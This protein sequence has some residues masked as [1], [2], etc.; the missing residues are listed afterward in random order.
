M[1]NSRV[2][3]GINLRKTGITKLN[4]TGCILGKGHRA[5]IP[6]TSSS[7]M[8][9]LLEVVHSDVNGPVEVPY[10]GVSR[11]FVTI[12]DDYSKWTTFYTMKQKSETFQC[13]KRYH[14]F[15]VKHTGTNL[16]S[17]NTTNCAGKSAEKLKTLRSDNGG[18]YLSNKF[19]YYLDDHV[20][21]HQLTVSYTSPKEWCWRTHES[22]PVR[23]RQI[24]A[25]DSTTR[26]N[27]LG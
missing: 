1:V 20:I 10:L 19:K 7:R 11:Y 14:K 16:A 26:Q 6:K 9:R 24:H 2:V 13:F 5:P 3:R 22:S 17:I 12:I 15:A 4:C 27:V 23:L 21:Q 25:P 8:T 18:E